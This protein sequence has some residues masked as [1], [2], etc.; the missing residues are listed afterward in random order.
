[1]WKRVRSCGHFTRTIAPNTMRR[2]EGRGTSAVSIVQVL[3]DPYSL[4]LAY[5]RVSNGETYG[6][7]KSVLAEHGGGKEGLEP[8]LTPS[9]SYFK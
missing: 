4:V 2:K 8:F 7:N 9:C 5:I 6:K 3:G 1:M